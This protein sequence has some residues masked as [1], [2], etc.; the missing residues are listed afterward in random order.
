MHA[1]VILALLVGADLIPPGTQYRAVTL[2]PNERHVFTVKD[3]ERVTGSSGRCIEEG[4]D[5]DYA[6]SMY[7]QAS[8][9][10]VRTATVWRKDGSRIHMMACAEDEERSPYLLKT[11]KELQ[12]Q[13][14]KMPTVTACVRN[15]KIELWGWLATQ[16]ELVPIHALEKKYGFEL[17]KSFVELLGVT[18]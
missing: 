13:L 14:K 6:E 3:I 1:S 2:E 16:K 10:G 17:V 18:E 15:G 7:L 8:C 4:L 9:G 12:K 11:R 5:G